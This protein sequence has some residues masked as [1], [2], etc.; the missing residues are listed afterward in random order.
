M[1][2]EPERTAHA[3]VSSIVALIRSHA[4]HQ[5]DKTAFILLSEGEAETDRLTYGELDRRAPA[6]APRPPAAGLP[7]GRV[8]LPPPPP[9]E[10]PGGMLGCLYPPAIPR[11]L[12]P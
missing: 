3:E 8:L 11:P 2:R 6:P 12:C 4:A 9:F 7:R 1:N 5:P 10:E